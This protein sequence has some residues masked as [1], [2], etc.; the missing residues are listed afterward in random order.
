MTFKTHSRMALDDVLREVYPQISAGTDTNRITVIAGNPSEKVLRGPHTTLEE[1]KIG[2]GAELKLEPGGT[3]VA[4]PSFGSLGDTIAG[5][6]FYFEVLF[7]LLD[8]GDSE[9]Q[10]LVWQV[11]MTLPTALAEIRLVQGHD[12]PWADVVCKQ[13]NIWRSLYILQILDSFL[14]PHD[15]DTICE[16]EALTFRRSFVKNGG[17]VAVV[18]V[19]TKASTDLGNMI[20]KGSTHLASLL[21]DTGFPIILRV[22]RLCLVDDKIAA[23]LVLSSMQVCMYPIF[24]CICLLSSVLQVFFFELDVGSERGR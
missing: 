6:S 14:C 16:Q 4:V 19:M 17:L 5:E 8:Q 9:V 11:L 10:V 21:R 24:V 20:Q 22:L 3:A 12:G 7:N 18:G 13:A 23:P 1:L 2:N 15:L